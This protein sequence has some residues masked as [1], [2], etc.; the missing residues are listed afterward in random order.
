MWSCGW[1]LLLVEEKECVIILI[2]SYLT[3]TSKEVAVFV[4]KGI[5]FCWVLW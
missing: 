5:D 4:E 3:A 2:G 1:C